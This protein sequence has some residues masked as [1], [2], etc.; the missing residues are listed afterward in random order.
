MNKNK[1]KNSLWI[2]LLLIVVIAALCFCAYRI[3]KNQSASSQ[4]ADSAQVQEETA[5]RQEELAKA[6][7][8]T[9]KA[10]EETIKVQEELAKAQEQLTES[11]K[12]YKEELELVTA[13][14]RSE[15]DGLGKIEG[16]IYVTGHKNP[17]TDTIGSSIAYA[18]L[19]QQLGYD[20]RAIVLGDINRETEL[21]L[22]RAGLEEPEKMEDVS[23]CNMVLMDHS[24]L[25]QSA[26]GLQDANILTIIDHH[27]VGSVTTGKPLIYDARPLGS[28]ATIVYIRY[29]NYGLT[30]SKQA[31]VA[32]LGAI[33]SDTHNLVPSATTEADRIAVEALSELAGVED[34]DAFYQEMFKALISYDGMT[35]E[36]IFF[37]DYKEYEAGGKKYGIGCIDVY[38][39]AEAREMAARM[40]DVVANSLSSSG[41]DM[42]FAQI[43]VFHDDLS[44]AYLL[45]SD[46]AADE[47]LQTA[48]G[49]RAERDGDAYVL[50]P[51]IS[52]KKVLAPAISDILEASPKE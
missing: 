16:P 32:M 17:D 48:F 43:S 19:L 44:L 10:K 2:I 27:G 50:K 46:E 20:A 52:R 33:L 26:D 13:L 47:V 18:E 5:K 39:E 31:A 11:E 7:E 12:L 22:E 36:E 14:N 42:A 25:A 29:Y 9:A 41:V 45:A 4:A 8:E 1:S 3:G 28:T 15:L 6:Q 34:V 49:D 23:G 30:P 40:K 38:D 21:V 51:G 24:E 35:D 37:H